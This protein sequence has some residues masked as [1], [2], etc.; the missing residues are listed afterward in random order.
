MT[1]QGTGWKNDLLLAFCA[2]LVVLTVN[3]VSGFPTLADYGGDN[4][5]MVRLV[6]VRDLLA[7]QSWFDLHQYRM[8][9][10]GGFL[11]HWSRLVDA[12]IALIIMASEA[13]GAGV[14][15]AE[16]AARIIWPT[17]LYGLTIFVIM[18]ASRRFAGANV[19]MP[20]VVLSTAA[21]FFLVIFSPG[22]I[23]HHN[24]QLL[25]TAASLCL[26]MV[27]PSWRPA[28][29][30]SGICSGLTLAV[31]META[32]YVAMLG[33]CAAVL[34]IVDEKERPTARGFGLGF[35][36]IASI[37]FVA[38]IR[39]ADWGVAQCDAFSSFQFA[40]AALSGFGLAAIAGLSVASTA[41]ARLILMLALAAMVAAVVLVLFP[42][43]LASP[44][45]GIDQ[46]VMD[47]IVEAQPFWRVAVTQPKLMAARYVTPFIAIVLIGLQLRSRRL[48]R[49]EALTA[50]LL[51]TAFIVSLWQVRGSTFSIAFAV[52]PLSAWIAKI[53]LQASAAPSWRISSRIVAAWLVSL[54]ATWAGVAVAAQSVVQKAPQQRANSDA[55][56]AVTCGKA[57]DF[58]DIAAMPATTVLAS[59][60]LGSG[61]LL[62]TS[63][64]PL[65]GPYHRNVGGNIAMLDAFLGTPDTAHSIIGRERVG[66]I[67]ICRG[68]TEEM[69]YA[70]EAPGGL[71]AQLLQG[72]V[73]DWLELDSSTAG[74]PIEIYRVR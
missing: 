54:N 36:G 63:H 49:E 71:A 28:A 41:R 43:C 40:V 74:K 51:V 34:F 65:A 16:R 64:R 47:D 27:S 57:G 72:N 4:D 14:E 59:S 9:V 45:A 15:T 61:I 58:A 8:G 5:S 31:G 37:V 7:G 23:D 53:R 38:T 19:A 2:T 70:K 66:L 55:D 52:L 62:F 35:A 6:E 60:N 18:R 50:V 39:P 1:A 12:P 26:L 56:H 44:Y 10:S 30:L 21:L 29:V 46:R 33:A 42:Q 24:V 25:L 73:P 3:A 22:V 67:A 11:M 48:R 20:S 69:T 68:D 32:P 13:L 17:L